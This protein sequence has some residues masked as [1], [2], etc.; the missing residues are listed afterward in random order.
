MPLERSRSPSRYIPP[1]V[2]RAQV[3]SE[4]AGPVK[5]VGR[6]LFLSPTP[7]GERADEAAGT[8]VP[9]ADPEL[10]DVVSRHTMDGAI[11]LVHIQRSYAIG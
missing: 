7:V 9:A 1:S 8:P 2:A 11:S 3:I 10:E 4:R 5:S 6:S